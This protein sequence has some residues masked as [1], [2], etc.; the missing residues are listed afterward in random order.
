MIHFFTSLPPVAYASVAF[1]V[2]TALLLFRM[3]FDDFAD[4]LDC[5][6]LASQ[7]DIISIFTGEWTDAHWA[8]AKL[9]FYFTPCIIS[10]F[11]AYNQLSRWLPGVFH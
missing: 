9:I 1:G 4:F 6:R 7:P 10:A 3:Y 11:L 2:L 8:G 5:L